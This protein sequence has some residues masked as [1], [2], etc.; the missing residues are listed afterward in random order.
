M[1]AFSINEEHG[2]GLCSVP[3]TLEVF[4]PFFVSL[5]LPY[6]VKR[7]EIVTVPI[8][9][10]NYLD[11]DTA[12]EL[13][14]HNDDQEFE[15]VNSTEKEFRK[16][17]NLYSDS[18][19]SV[20]VLMKFH[21]LG[22]VSIK[23]TALSARAGDSIVKTIEVEAEGVTQYENKPTLIDLRKS[24]EL[25]KTLTVEVPEYAVPDS[26]RVEVKCVGDVFGSTMQ[27]LHKLI[28]LPSGCGEQNM[29]KFVPN[30][31]ILDYLTSSKQVKPHIEKMALDYMEIG[32]QTELHYKHFDGSYS[33]FGQSD[34]SGSTWLTAFV[35]RSFRQ[36]SKYIFIDEEIV[37]NGL[38]WL[39]HSQEPDGSFRERGQISNKAMQG[40][41]GNGLALTSYTLITFVESSVRMK[42]NLWIS[43]CYH[44]S[45]LLVERRFHVS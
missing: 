1:D 12:A 20:N 30:I 10:F 9:V 39:R 25:D 2:L 28:R 41:S 19:A 42:I 32:Y 17:L 16:K 5:T 14:I 44:L 22:T 15:F 37:R 4:Q 45:I 34:G 6:S 40:G 31:V 43:V 24:G 11:H 21:K 8:V 26:A 38:E 27:N 33:V 7:N 29:L 18:G 36:A 3:K 13:I 35:T 23:M